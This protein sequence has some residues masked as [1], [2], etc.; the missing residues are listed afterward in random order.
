MSREL[1]DG[2][3][4]ASSELT[5]MNVLAITKGRERYI[6]LY[7]DASHGATLDQIAEFANDPDLSFSWRDAAQVSQRI[8][9]LKAQQDAQPG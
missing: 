2:L 4:G 8:G 1:I 6:F 3:G 9:R 5:P 7:D